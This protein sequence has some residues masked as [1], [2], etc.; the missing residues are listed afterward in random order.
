MSLHCA[1][2][3]LSDQPC[4]PCV[5]DEEEVAA[6]VSRRGKQMDVEEDDDDDDE[7]EYMTPQGGFVCDT[8]VADG[9]PKGA[10]IPTE[11]QNCSMLSQ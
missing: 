8:V 4:H 6:P 11:V 10:G 9:L 3:T 5:Q 1:H 7:H 2:S